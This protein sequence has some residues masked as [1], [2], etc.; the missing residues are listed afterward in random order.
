MEGNQRLE[1]RQQPILAV[2]AAEPPIT[3][4]ALAVLAALDLSVCGGLNKENNDELCT[5]Q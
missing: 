2:A 5:Y 3:L 1:R 4:L